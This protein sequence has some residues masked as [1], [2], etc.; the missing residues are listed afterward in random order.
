MNTMEYQKIY[1]LLINLLRDETKS[2]II[3]PSEEESSVLE[4][5]IFYLINILSSGKIRVQNYI[6]SAF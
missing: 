4:F 3:D 1:R 2:K 6:F 5:K